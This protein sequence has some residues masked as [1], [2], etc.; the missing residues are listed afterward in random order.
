MGTP[1]KRASKN[2]N[3]KGEKLLSSFDA[4]S[5]EI[6]QSKFQKDKRRRKQE[7]RSLLPWRFSS[8]VEETENKH[9]ATVQEQDGRRALLELFL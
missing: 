7:V 6:F 4:W 8:S 2:R 1:I 9:P 3:L 5:I